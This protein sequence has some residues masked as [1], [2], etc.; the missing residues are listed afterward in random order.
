MQTKTII[1]WAVAIGGVGG[2]AWSAMTAP[3]TH[4]TAR[5]KGKMVALPASPEE[6]PAALDREW[7]SRS[8]DTPPATAAAPADN[9]ADV[10]LVDDP[11]AKASPR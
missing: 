8:D 5:S 11:Q 6:R 3:A 4:V 10:G 2:L 9:A 1:I 7:T